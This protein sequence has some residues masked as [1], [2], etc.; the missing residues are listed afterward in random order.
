MRCRTITEAQR[1]A[2]EMV[3]DANSDVCVWSE[4]ELAN[5]SI[6]EKLL[7]GAFAADESSSLDSSPGSAPPDSG[8]AEF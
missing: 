4:D 7:P 6:E 5:S 1:N 3:A 8:N 2:M